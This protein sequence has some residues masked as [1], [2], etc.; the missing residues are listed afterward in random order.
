M[1]DCITPKKIKLFL[2]LLLLMLVFITAVSYW[3]QKFDPQQTITPRLSPYPRNEVLVFE[4]TMSLS[5]NIPIKPPPNNN[6]HCP[7]TSIVTVRQKGR[8]GNQIFKYISV[9]ALAKTTGREPY[10]PSCLITELEKI[11]RN[12]AV[13]PLSY[14]AYCPIQ[15]YPLEVTVDQ[16]DHSN[17]SIIPPNNIQLPTYIAPFVSKIRQIFQFKKYIIDKS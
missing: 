10:V 16:V 9:L 6:I 17:G 14:L 11:F 5:S 4:S 7:Q 12:L 3:T 1:S 15:E 13:P 8:I 2:T